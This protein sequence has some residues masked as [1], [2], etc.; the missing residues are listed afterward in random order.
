MNLTE[1]YSVWKLSAFASLLWVLI[2]PGTGL[3]NPLD[4]A[5]RSAERIEAHMRFLADDL[6]QGRGTGTPGH[7]L[8]A[9]YVAA[10]LAQIGVQPAGDNGSYYQSVPMLGFR[11]ADEGSLT[12]RRTGE[13]AMRLTF[14]EDY[15]PGPNALS[16]QFRLSAPVVF[17]GFGV[18]APHQQWDD[19]ETLDAKGKIVVVLVGAPPLLQSEQRAYYGS[20]QT[21]QATAAAHGAIGLVVMQTP[22]AERRLPFV[23]LVERWRGWQSTWC[24]PGGG[25]FTPGGEAALLAYLNLAGAAKLFAASPVPLGQLYRDADSGRPRVFPLPVTLDA[26]LRAEIKPLRSANVVGI[27][28]GADDALRHEAVVLSSHLDHLG[29]NEKGHGDTIYNGAMD[30]ASGVATHLEVARA[31]AEGPRPRRTIMFLFDTAEEQSMA[32]SQY[33]ARHPAHSGTLVANVNLDMPMLTYAFT[34]V[35][36]FGAEHSS[37]GLAVRRAAERSGIVLSPDPVPDEGLFTR[38]DHFSFVEQGVPSVYL[39]TGFAGDG[40]RS[41]GVFVAQHYHQPSDDLSQPIDYRVGARFAR[42]NYDVAREIADGDVRP[43]WVP[44]DFFGELFAQPE[45]AEM[46]APRSPE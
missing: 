23:R 11:A 7:E 1:D 40:A 24:A 21:K 15:I 43:A 13:S 10:Q 4:D 39:M 26:E 42:L 9:A 19:Y 16:T 34:D 44:G 27:I 46:S 12:L 3:A 31:F 18:V 5:A 35:V 25:P 41:F 8:A 45:R 37:L 20:I 33:F 32:G 14:G 22:A 2:S 29:I 36:A 6:L 28:E 30:N 17:A 38:S